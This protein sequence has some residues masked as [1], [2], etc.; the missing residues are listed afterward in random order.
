MHDFAREVL[1]DQPE[2]I[3]DFGAEY[4]K[5]MEEVTLNPLMTDYDNNQCF[6]RVVNLITKRRVQ[7]FPHQKTACLQMATTKKWKKVPKNNKKMR[8]R[9]KLQK[10]KATEWS[11][12]PFE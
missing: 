10:L 5:A 1:R 3:Y 8:S 6:V 7:L 12:H 11:N 2:D 4:F 9:T